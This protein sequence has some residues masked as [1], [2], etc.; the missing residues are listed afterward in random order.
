MWMFFCF[1]KDEYIPCYAMDFLLLTSHKP[2]R[3]R[4]WSLEISRETKSTVEEEEKYL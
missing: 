2:S 1:T 4:H 3:V